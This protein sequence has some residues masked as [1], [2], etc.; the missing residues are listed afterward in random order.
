MW[1]CPRCE[2]TFL[3]SHPRVC[4]TWFFCKACGLRLEPMATLEPAREVRRWTMGD[5]REEVDPVSRRFAGIE[6]D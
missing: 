3:F 1:Y 4:T 6:N 5:Q 2:Y